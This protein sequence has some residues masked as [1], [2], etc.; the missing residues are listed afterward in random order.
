MNPILFDFKFIQ[1]RWYSIFLLIAFAIGVTLIYRE[2][3][4]LNVDKNYLFNLTFWAIIFGLLGARFYYVI[5]N[6]SEYS[7]NLL[8]I[9]KVWHGGLAIHGGIIAGLLTIIIYTKKYNVDIYKIIDIFV[10]ALLIGQAIGRWGNFF[11]S[12]AHGTATTLLTLQ[13]LHL[14]QFIIDGMNINGVYYQPTF[15]YESIFCFIGFCLLLFLRRYK[16][17]K[18]G[19]VLA[20]YLI[21]YGVVRFIIEISRTDALMLGGFKV[22]QLIS[23]VFVIAGIVLF[24]FKQKKGHFEDLYNE[25]IS[26]LLHF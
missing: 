4:R 6:F 5:F 18:N 1:I 25:E 14:P 26:E 17:I 2:G 24:V 23:V 21:W 15:F 3:S 19:Q 16:Y 10:P 9:F 11:N 8:E 12:E 22:A 7:D 13:K 20:C